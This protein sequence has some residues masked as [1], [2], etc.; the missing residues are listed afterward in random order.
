MA[1]YGTVW[2]AKSVAPWRSGVIYWHVLARRTQRRTE[3]RVQNRQAEPAIKLRLH[4]LGREVI[5]NCKKRNCSL[6][7][8]ESY[9]AAV[10]ACISAVPPFCGPRLHFRR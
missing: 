6:A 9:E 2:Q 10:V 8:G 1:R 5:A 4:R 3:R 7:E